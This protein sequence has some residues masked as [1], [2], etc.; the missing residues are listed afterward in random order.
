MRINHWGFEVDSEVPTTGVFNANN[1]EYLMDDV[2]SGDTID[3]SWE[4]HKK[5]CDKYETGEDCYHEVDS[6]RYLIGFVRVKQS[7][8]KDDLFE[9]DPEAEYSAIIN[10]DRNTVQVIK[11]KWG[12]RCALC[13]PCYPGQGD[14]DTPGDFLAFSVPPDLV[15]DSD[16]WNKEIRSRIFELEEGNEK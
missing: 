6:D 5:E 9:P 15:G 14:G 10:F 7:L 11:S 8:G 13:S 12:I 3:L 16:E 1:I 2:A 4:D